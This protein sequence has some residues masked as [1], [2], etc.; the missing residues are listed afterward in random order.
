MNFVYEL[1]AAKSDS[2]EHADWIEIDAITSSNSSSSYEEFASQIHISGT[3][4]VMESDEEN[5]EDGLDEDDGSGEFSYQISDI[6]WAEIE[7]RHRV[8]GDDA[9]YY[10]FEVTKGSITLKDS[11]ESSSY[12]FQ[13]LL[14]TFGK[15]AGPP[16]TYGDRIFEHLSAHTG[17]SYLGGPQNLARQ[18]R[19]AF[20]RPDNSGFETALKNLCRELKCGKVKRNA[21]LLGQQQDSHLD[22]VV[23][24]PLLDEMEGQ[25]I[26][27][28]QCATG[29]HWD[30]KLTELQPD[31]FANE[32][33]DDRFHPDPFRMFFV[34]RCI[35][36]RLW[37]HFTNIAGIIFDR[38]RTSELARDLEGDLLEECKE[39]T[40]HVINR[41]RETNN[42]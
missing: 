8:C 12:V 27:F 40:L 9:G 25:L 17:Q 24:R 19:F 1:P 15:D 4:D 33:L 10:P 20:P 3:T 21:A 2:V 36:N 42:D 34:P 41:M 11:W 18:F 30:A 6:T 31:N 32:W 16:G 28:G 13:L 23:W 14:S 37:T 5:E 35:E 22:V 38:C 29:K 26:G 7:R 39:W